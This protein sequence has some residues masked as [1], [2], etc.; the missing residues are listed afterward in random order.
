M[1][2]RFVHGDQRE[3]RPGH[4]K[5]PPR[6]VIVVVGQ[7]LPAGLP[8]ILR[9]EQLLQVTAVLLLGIRLSPEALESE[10]GELDRDDEQPVRPFGTA[11]NR[12]YRVGLYLGM[13]ELIK[14]KLGQGLDDGGGVLV[15]SQKRRAGENQ[16]QPEQQGQRHGISQTVSV[17]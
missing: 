9:K 8:E 2:Q 17:S 10:V 4:V 16:D 6:L 3:D 15:G 12:T 11:A 1:R 7:G 5:P 13:S 14:P